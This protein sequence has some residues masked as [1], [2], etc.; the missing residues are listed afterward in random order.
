MGSKEWR[1]YSETHQAGFYPMQDSWKYYEPVGFIE[2]TAPLTLLPEPEIRL[3]FHEEINRFV[4]REIEPREEK[5]KAEI[6]RTKGSNKIVNE[7]GVLYAR[8]GLK[9]KAKELFRKILLEEEYL[10]ALINMGN[11]YYLSQDMDAALGL[12][13]RASRKA[14]TNP[15]VLLCLSRVHHAMENYGMARMAYDRLKSIDSTLTLRFTYLDPGLKE[16]ERQS[17]F[18]ERRYTVIWEEE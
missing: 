14:P 16:Y 9:E 3:V 5:L 8:Y 10:P 6:Q 1:E 15:N 17:N 12:Y 13:E 2:E 7:L 4:Q 18:A 11:L